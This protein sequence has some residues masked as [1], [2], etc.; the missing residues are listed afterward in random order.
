MRSGN[1]MRTDGRDT[2]CFG[3]PSTSETQTDQMPARRGTGA[4]ASGKRGRRRAGGG[5]ARAERGR[6]ADAVVEPLRRPEEGL[7]VRRAERHEQ[8]GLQVRRCDAQRRAAARSSA[9]NAV[10]GETDAYKFGDLSR[11]LD[12]SAKAKVNEIT[13]ESEQNLATCRGGSTRAPRT[14]SPSCRPRTS[15]SSATSRSSSCSRASQLT[16]KDATMLLK[17]LLSFNVGLSSVGGLLPIKFLVEVLNYSLLVDV[18]ERLAGMVA[19]E[20][21]KRVK[22]ALTGD[23]EYKLGDLTKR[24]VKSFTGKEEYAFGDVS[25]EVMRRFEEPGGPTPRRRSATP[26]VRRRS[27]S[28]SRRSSTAGMRGS[29]RATRRTRVRRNFVVVRSAGAR[30]ASRGGRTRRRTA[31]GSNSQ[32]DHEPSRIRNSDGALDQ[33]KSTTRT[34][35]CSFPR[36]RARRQRSA[37]GADAT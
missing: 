25:R 32:R 35:A 30:L 33:R 8:S 23:S 14:R 29:L 19:V 7:R 34:H 31:H 3:P 17:A 1:P 27:T 6:A 4:R 24:A 11:W 37:V 22:E 5:T 16:M 36:R 21:D 18:G 9:I 15:T 28:S 2:Y 12:R 20:I 10:T 13:G 26:T